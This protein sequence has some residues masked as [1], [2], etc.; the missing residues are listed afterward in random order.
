MTETAALAKQSQTPPAVNNKPKTL[1]DLLGEVDVKKRFHEIL[2]K[3]AGAFMSN[4]LSVSQGSDALQSASPSS[5]IAAAMKA[6]AL[7]LPIEP[8]LGM[9]AIVPYNEK[10]KGMTAVFQIMAR[11]F[12]QLALRSGQY[13]Q[14]NLARVYEGQLVEH[15]EF[16]G[17]VTLNAKLKK[18]DKVQG[19]FFFFTLTNGY[20]CQAY[21]SAR[22]CMEHGQR[23]SQ[24]FYSANGK[25]CDDPA[26]PKDKQGRVELDKWDG[27]LTEGS[28]ADQMSGKT[29]VKITLSHKGILSVDMQNGQK[30]DQAAFDESGSE[31]YPDAIPGEKVPEGQAKTFSEAREAAPE[32][33]QGT[34]VEFKVKRGSKSEL[35]GEECK[36]LVSEDDHKYFLNHDGFFALGKASKDAGTTVKGRFI[37]KEVP[38]TDPKVIVRWLVALELKKA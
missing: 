14:I 36:L 6:A 15:D 8:S 7:D 38:G 29:I 33:A 4:L 20:E 1:K 34:E 32:E 11:G 16:K 9:A 31:R 25:W 26:L 24:S 18:S 21:W 12:V 10:G 22:K 19:Y 30:A 35:G 27:T 5:I 23:Y 28:G 3:R 2:G 17:T 13:K 37:E